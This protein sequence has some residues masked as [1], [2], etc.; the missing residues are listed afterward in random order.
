[1]KYDESITGSVPADPPIGT[2][3]IQ[4][5]HHLASLSN[6][7]THRK[8]IPHRS[9]TLNGSTFSSPKQSK[10]AIAVVSPGRAT[11]LLLFVVLYVGAVFIVFVAVAYAVP[12]TK[13]GESET[14]DQREREFD[15]KSAM[16]VLYRWR[17]SRRSCCTR[18]S[19]RRSLII[20]RRRVLFDES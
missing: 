13:T 11:L 7:T 16:D 14:Q 17:S 5:D 2:T 20:E 18:D 1:L 3:S 6:R 4:N 10:S 12:S 15:V 9:R 19:I 8:M